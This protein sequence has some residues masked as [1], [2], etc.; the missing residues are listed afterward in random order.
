VLLEL[1]DVIASGGNFPVSVAA[2]KDLVYVLN[3]GSVPNI[4]GFE[5][6]HMG[7][8]TPIAGS[9]RVLPDTPYTQIGF[10]PRGRALVVTDLRNNNL[11]VFPVGKDGTPAAA[12]I[13]TP[14]AGGGPFAFVFPAPHT[15]LV[16]EVGTN[17][18]SSY[19]LGKDG[20]LQVLTPSVPNMQAATCWIVDVKG[21]Y[22]FTANPGTMSLSSFRVPHG[23][24]DLE[25][26]S[27]VA[28]MGQRPLDLATAENGRFLYALDPALGGIGVFRV[29]HDGSLVDLGPL[30]AGLPIH[31]Q[32]LAAR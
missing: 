17:A 22:A 5:L 4:T 31:A 7:H 21:R 29:G 15:L 8:L 32:G 13:V 20:S 9:T 1:T 26:I 10:D 11:L 23:K 25:L 24:Q 27:G 14:S 2:F 19:K 28:G 18:V 12:P 16:A 3:A 6:D 30:P